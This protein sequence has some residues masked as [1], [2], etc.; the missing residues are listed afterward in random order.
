MLAVV[1][2]IAPINYKTKSKIDRDMASSM[3]VL[4]VFDGL[5][6][7]CNGPRGLRSIQ[8]V[9]NSTNLAIFVNLK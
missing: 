1:K 9:I 4:A 7:P 5:Y 6:Y 2:N 8:N 3:L